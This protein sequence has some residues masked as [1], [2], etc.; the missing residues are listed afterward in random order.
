MHQI[1]K[2]YLLNNSVER[3]ID[4]LELK[5]QSIF[6]FY[7]EIKVCKEV[8]Y[9]KLGSKYYKTIK[10]GVA[11]SKEQ[12][13]VKISKALY[14]KNK[15]HTIGKKIAKVRYQL[16]HQERSEQYYID[17]FS[18][19][20]KNIY[21]LEVSFQNQSQKLKFKLPSIFKN[22]V[23]KEVTK[24]ER[25]QNKNLALL[26]DPEKNPYNIYAIFKSI[27][28]GRI[29]NLQSVIF[30]EM[31][32]S[33][34][35][36]I[37]LYK[38]FIEL[39][40]SH[41]EI[42]QS[43][44]KEGIVSFNA[45]LKNSRI[46]LEEYRNIFDKNIVS[47]VRK[48]L[49]LMKCALSKEKD[50]QF[51]KRE[52]YKL[53]GII[54]PKE[55]KDFLNV[56]DEHIAVEQHKIMKFLKTREFSIIFKQYELLLKENNRSFTSIEAQT[57][58]LNSLNYKMMMHYKEAMMVCGKYEGCEDKQSF[59]TMKKPLKVVRA[60]VDEFHMAMTKKRAKMIHKYTSRVIKCVNQIESIDKKALI[61]KTYISHLKSKPQTAEEIV[62]RIDKESKIRIKEK[63][64]A[65][66][67]SVDNFKR[68]KQ[69]FKQ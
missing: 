35:V 40:I 11:G 3:L 46:L 2:K 56:L 52:L 4:D 20:L 45:A 10:T 42:I 54:E 37:A 61:V 60:L 39:K 15:K 17:K 66:Q 14:L 58:I 59:D 62:H 9:S 53:E 27:E 67:K 12:N 25:Y 69:L 6:E 29:T 13:S 63:S 64:E 19:G 22:L 55:M 68:Q 8:K 43:E 5:K 57:S 36:R 30:P 26:G 38:L 18:H 24:D 32:T 34:S 7:T 44:A 1:E 31:K 48:H 16:S 41:D 65:L 50:L 49:K 51:I 23:I 33:D 47:K 21:L 28:L